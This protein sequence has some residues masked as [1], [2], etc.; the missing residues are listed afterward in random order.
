MLIARKVFIFCEILLLLT[1][2]GG[3]AQSEEKVTI[4]F[5]WTN[6]FQFAGYY[7]ALEK[8]YFK[9]AG[10]DVDLIQVSGVAS[11]DPVL[12]GKYQFG[13]ATASTLLG[14]E[15]Y[16]EISVLA[17]I[18]QQSPVSLIALKA[19]GINNLRDLNNADIVGGTEIAAMLASAGVNLDF[20]KFHG[21]TSDF[22][23][24]ISGKYDATSYFIT[25]KTK[26][27]GNDS[28]L[29][30]IFRPIEY[31]INFYGECLFTSRKEVATDPE[32]AEKIR[33]AVIKGWEYAITHEDEIIELIQKKYQSNL[34]TQ[35]L[36]SE[37]EVIIHSL[38]QPKFY[39]IGNMQYS[40]WKQMA[41]ILY[42][43]NLINRKRDLDGFIY[44]P[45]KQ[46]TVL[47][48]RVI[49]ISSII[50]AIAAIILL[51]LLLYNR[52]LKKAVKIRTRS[53]EKAN[54]EMD[55]F[56]YSISHDI[57][58][59]LSSVQGIINLMKTDKDNQDQYIELI[60]TSISKLDNYTRDILDYTRNS[61][62][63]LKIQQVDLAKMVDK[64]I[65]QVKYADKTGNFNIEK[66]IVSNIKV[67]SDSWRLEVILN[68]LISNAIKYQNPKRD[69]SYVVIE[70]KVSDEF[71]NISLKDNGIGIGPDHLDKIFEMFYR[72]SEDSQ[73]SG[74]GLYIVKETISLMKGNIEITSEKNEGTVINIT[75]PNRK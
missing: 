13:V 70:V 63:K 27:L 21:I 73:G 20:V 16:D 14:S 30:N 3:Q 37:A 40:K 29:F 49:I 24:L 52:Q 1:A 31:G 2:V 39:D 67:W 26:L 5:D 69:D 55:R 56:V 61:R 75:L 18:F 38:M 42:N 53:L 71:F 44:D 46:D 23:A 74:L 10:Y 15:R 47:I 19:H 43:F 45:P 12:D 22:K 41:E 50:I 72:A 48:K 9:Q 65:A 7:A 28:L 25:D 32:R 57:R 58:S 17:A 54:E 11:L 8:G 59:P 4:Y 33:Q 68:N 62:A 66:N 64:C 35:E 34:T 60:N 51:I 36:Q 6:Q